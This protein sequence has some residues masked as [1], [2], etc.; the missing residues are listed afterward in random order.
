MLGGGS[1]RR[2]GRGSRCRQGGSRSGRC[3]SE[4]RGSAEQH[5]GRELANAGCNN[6]DA[7]C[8]DYYARRH[9]YAW[10]Q[11]ERGWRNGDTQPAIGHAAELAQSEHHAFKSGYEHHASKCRH[12]SDTNASQCQQWIDNNDTKCRHGS[13]TFSSRRF[14]GSSAATVN[15]TTAT[16]EKGT[17]KGF[18]FLLP[19]GAGTAAEKYD[20]L[21]ISLRKS[22]DD[23]P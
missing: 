10:Y 5:A 11:S 3:R 1:G 21:Q 2:R 18:P 8:H 20:G 6:S 12:G 16:A 23:M 22:C 9:D 19:Q 4:W 15:P 7:G 14:D 13:D 17:C